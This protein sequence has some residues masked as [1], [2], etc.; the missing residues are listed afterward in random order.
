MDI[1]LDLDDQLNAAAPPVA[2]RTTAVRQALSELIDSTAAVTRTTPRR[3]PL[4][5]GVAAF[6]LTAVAGVGTAAAAGLAAGWWNSPDAVTQHSTNEAG[7]SCDVTYA[8]RA[9]H[10]PDHP[11]SRGE[12]AAAMNATADF[13]R[14]FDY[15][16]VE[17]MGTNE[18]L[19][20]L[21]AA[22]SDALTDKGLPVEAVS[23][24]LATDCR[25]E[26]AK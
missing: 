1:N 24:A 7:E 9:L 21:Y 17:A 18:A 25:D 15:T 16:A 8:P 23:I 6:T 22:L 12:R 13:L 2:E 20:T 19:G 26:A 4:R 10:D 14:R 5:I 11:V 3:R